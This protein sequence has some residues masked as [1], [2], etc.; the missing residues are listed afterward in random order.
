MKKSELD[1][2]E[3][4]IISSVEAGEWK[5]VTGITARKKK[6]EGIAKNTHNKLFNLVIDVAEE[7]I[8]LLMQKSIE[9][10]IPYQNII[11]ALI[12]NY[13]NGR[14]KLNV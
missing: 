7:D 9:V 2:Y 6:M 5:Q 3:H 11:S 12:H 1:T 10:G 14:I 13:S 4:D 8:N